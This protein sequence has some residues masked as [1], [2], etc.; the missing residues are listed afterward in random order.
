MNILANDGIDGLAKRILEDAGHRVDADHLN[1]EELFQRI[2]E[3]DALTVRSA[4]QVTQELIDAAAPN[5]KLIARG[6]VGMDNIDVDYARSRGIAVFNTPGASSLSVAEL[7]FAHLFS[8]ARFLYDT[9][10]KMPLSGHTDF[11]NLKKSCARGIE[12]RGK[13]LGIVGFG[14]IGQEVARIGLGI[15]MRILVCDQQEVDDTIRISFA[16][17]VS[18]DLP[19]RKTELIDLYKEADFVS[20]HVPFTE[21]PLLGAAEFAFLKPGVG[22]VN[23]ARGGVIDEHALLD[24]LNNG[25][26]AF[27]C[28]DVFEGEPV[29]NQD[30]LSHP[31]ISLSPH[32]GAATVEAQERVGIELAHLIVDHFSDWEGASVV[33]L[34]EMSGEK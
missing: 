6:G 27:A 31:R 7:V 11:L 12:L 21:R 23:T 33:D 25:S 18:V 30:L 20:F 8:G 16:G 5:L 26:V 22:L 13:T 15:G 3:Y 29:P 2:G 17:G 28:L 10:R 34:G 4:T 32:I 24:A 1:P 19:V 9:Q 14:R